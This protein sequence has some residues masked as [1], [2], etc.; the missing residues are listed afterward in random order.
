MAPPVQSIRI[1]DFLNLV[2]TRRISVA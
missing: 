1:A 2:G